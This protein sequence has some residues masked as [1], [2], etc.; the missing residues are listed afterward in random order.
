MSL[1]IHLEDKAASFSASVNPH[2]ALHTVAHP[3]P[4]AEIVET[5][6]VFRQF[7]TDD[8]LST[9]SRD[10]RV[11]GS[12]TNVPF[13]VPANLNA[14]ET[15]DRYITML[16]FA[17]ADGGAVLN[18]FGNIG[19]LANGCKLAYT[20]PG[21]GEIIISDQLTTNWEFIRMAATSPYGGNAAAWKANNVSGPSE[22]FTPILDIRRVFGLPWGIRLPAGSDARL[23][24][25]V[26]DNTSAVDLFDCIAYGFEQSLR[27]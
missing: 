24:L 21:A 23:T 19:A 6:I 16:S 11:D 12:V 14:A 4:P 17:I 9:G 25:T 1:K 3:H 2:G 27:D 18:E 15:R 7:L 26:R 13:W 10:M 5:L 20:E 22:G 8:G